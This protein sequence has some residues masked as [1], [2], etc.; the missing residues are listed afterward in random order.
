MHG[1]MEGHGMACLR[2]GECS[3]WGEGAK[4]VGGMRLGFSQVLS[5]M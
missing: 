3:D 5:K 2:K 1:G 4:L